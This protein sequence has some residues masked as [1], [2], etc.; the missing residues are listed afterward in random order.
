MGAGALA[1]NPVFHNRTKH[2]EVDV[3][4]IREKIVAGKLVVQ[5]VPTA[6]RKANVFNKALPVHQFLLL[7]NKLNMVPSPRLSLRG[8]VNQYNKSQLEP[9]S[10]ASTTSVSRVNRLYNSNN[11]VQCTTLLTVVRRPSK[12]QDT[13]QSSK[14][15]DW[16]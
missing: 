5:Y 7:R 9:S 14:K 8:H 10:Q 4:F 1:H 15:L 16:R 2:I 12:Y 6:M 3:H 11:Q 13:H